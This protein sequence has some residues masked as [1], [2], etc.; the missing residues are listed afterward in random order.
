MDVEMDHKKKKKKKSVLPSVVSQAQLSCVG[1]HGQD[2]EGS[3]M[4]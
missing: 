1:S 3:D 2:Q 4:S